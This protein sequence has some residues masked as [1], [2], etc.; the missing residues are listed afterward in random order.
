MHYFFLSAQAS[1]SEE[2]LQSLRDEAA[3]WEARSKETEN[4]LVE[5]TSSIARWQDQVQE[6]EKS[7]TDTSR[8]LQ[9][10]RTSRQQ[11]GIVSDLI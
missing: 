11:V 8:A 7:A 3:L 10:A 6:Q 1:G 5:M 2:E 4:M 9:E